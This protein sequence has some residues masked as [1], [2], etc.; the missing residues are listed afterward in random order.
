M[1]W[2]ISQALRPDMPNW[3]GDTAFDLRRTWAMAPGVPV[4]VSAL[5]ASSHAGTHADAPLHYDAAGR[6]IDAVALDPY[7]GLAEVVDGRGHDGLITKDRV[8]PRLKSAAARILIRT[9]DRAPQDAW[10]SSFPGIE[11][12]L[13]DALAARGTVLIGV[14]TPSLDPEQSKTM[15]AHL[16]VRKHGMAILENLVLDDVP[17]GTY[18]LIALPLKIAGCD[19]APV[20]AVLRDLAA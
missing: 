13:I 17:F 18:E 1:I 8:L 11:P 4:N 10:D 16:A 15:A 14:D 5:T 6:A 12:A 20:R 7:L 2:D 19:A 9:Y 3:P